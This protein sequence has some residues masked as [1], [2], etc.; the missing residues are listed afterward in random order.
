MHWH[1]GLL[2]RLHPLRGAA[3]PFSITLAALLALSVFNAVNPTPARADPLP[4]FPQLT[5][6]PTCEAQPSPDGDVVTVTVRGYSFS[7]GRVVSLYWDGALVASPGDA[8]QV[9]ATGYIEATFSQT[10]FGSSDPTSHTINAYYQDQPPDDSGTVPP[11]AQTYINVPCPTDTS[12]ITIT[13]DCGAAGAPVSIHIDGGGFFP[14]DPL[15]VV[16]KGLFDDTVYGSLDA[17]VP[18]DPNAVSLDVTATLPGT[19]AYRV[20]A[21]QQYPP[22]VEGFDPLP[23]ATAYFVVPCSVASVNPTCGPAGS[24]P[25]RYSIQVSG[26]GFLPGLPV[27]IVFDAT[28]QAEYF[29]GQFQVNQDGT[30]GPAEIQPYARG[31]GVYSIEVEQSNDSPVLHRTV[32]Q[33]TV[34]CPPPGGVTLNPTCASPQFTGDQPQAF[35]LNV[36]GGGFQP[37]LPITVTFDPDGKSGPA[38]TPETTQVAA[39]GGG[40]FSATITVAA[41]PAGQY[42]VAVEQQVNGAVIQGNVPPFNVPCAPPSAKITAVKPN[43]GD[44]VNV[45]PAPYSIEVVGRGFIP[46]FVQLIFDFDGTQELFSTT[47]NANGRFDATITPT[48]RSA[49]SYRIAAQQADANSMLDQVFASFGVPCTATLLTVTPDDTS[50]GFVVAVHGTGF[51]ASRTIELR[52]SYGIGAAQPIEVT[53]DATGS[54]DRQILIFAHDFTG[55]RQVTAGLQ[56]NANAFPGAQATLLVEAGQGSPPSYPIFG[57]DPSDQ[58]PIILRR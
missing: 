1:V 34:E 33:F 48:A 36:A 50:P 24:G 9:Q 56:G 49:G 14:Q 26:Q 45:N 5:I 52:W 16:V 22:G 57:G 51:P 30:W 42:R 54:F 18:A 25:D 6:D 23:A 10:I 43:C 44:D 53:T 21:A 7:I 31:P 27:T 39:D 41:R 40:N 19:G 11:V 38:F 13:P 2:L 3:R 12:H 8:I 35:Q 29:S 32:T 4:E 37:N 55:E 46:G 17:A 15:G 47:A 58:P 28:G 20:I